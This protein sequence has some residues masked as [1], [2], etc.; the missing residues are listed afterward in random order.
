[1]GRAAAALCH[2]ATLVSSPGLR[3]TDGRDLAGAGGPA[4]W[5]LPQVNKPSQ[6]GDVPGKGTAGVGK[7]Q[8]SVEG[9]VGRQRRGKGAPSLEKNPMAG[10]PH[11]AA[12]PGCSGPRKALSLLLSVPKLRAGSQPWASSTQEG[13]SESIRHCKREAALAPGCSPAWCGPRQA[14]PLSHL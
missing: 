3:E 10:L 9:G 12:Y 14:Q 6:Q 2:G 8:H 4:G 11:E 7:G 5:V 13:I 1:M